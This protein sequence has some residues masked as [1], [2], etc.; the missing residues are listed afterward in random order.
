MKKM[1]NIIFKIIAAIALTATT[2]FNVELGIFATG[3]YMIIKCIVHKQYSI[4]RRLIFEI[5][6]IVAVN[7]HA[8]FNCWTMTTDMINKFV[9]C[10]MVIDILLIASGAIK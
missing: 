5:I 7:I 9:L 8:A 4:V 10:F 2:I 1:I 6:L 3:V